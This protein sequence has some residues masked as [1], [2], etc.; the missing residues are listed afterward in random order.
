M[1]P[2]HPDGKMKLSEASIISM[3]SCRRAA[4]PSARPCTSATDGR[5]PCKEP[6]EHQVQ[7]WSAHKAACKAALQDAT[8]S[9]SS[10]TG[11]GA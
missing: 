6:K 11:G 2:H 3:S 7:D 9:G 10:G 1:Q 5:R 8:D 4:A